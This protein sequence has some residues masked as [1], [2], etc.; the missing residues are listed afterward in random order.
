MSIRAMNA[1]LCVIRTERRIPAGAAY[2]MGFRIGQRE[3]AATVVLAPM[4]KN[5]L[6][7]SVLGVVADRKSSDSLRVS[8]A[9][10]GGR[11]GVEL[12]R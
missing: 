3:N 6:L 1:R 12:R 11:G 2:D 8:S 5:L 4:R 9:R 7:F 10:P